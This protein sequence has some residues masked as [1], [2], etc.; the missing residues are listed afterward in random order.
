MTLDGT[1]IAYENSFDKGNAIIL[2]TF[3]GQE[4]YL[5]PV[6]MHPLGGLLARWAGLSE[7]RLR[8]PGLLEMRQMYSAKGRWVF[9]FNHRDK[10]SSVEFRRALEKPASS[11]REVMTGQKIVPAGSELH[12]KAEVPA[13]S[14]RIYR[15]DF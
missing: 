3:A 15:I 14:V 11:I 7:P 5:H 9:F 6:A 4:N 8:A 12:L 10:P 2:G 1:P 13:G